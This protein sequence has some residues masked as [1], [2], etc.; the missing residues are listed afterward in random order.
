MTT[1]YFKRNLLLNLYREEKISLVCFLLPLKRDKNVW[2]LQAIS[3]V[4][5]PL[6]FLLVTLSVSNL[7][8]QCFLDNGWCTYIRVDAPRWQYFCPWDI[9]SKNTEVGSHSLLQGIFLSKKSNPALP[10]SDRFLTVWAVRKAH[11]LIL[12]LN[13]ASPFFPPSSGVFTAPLS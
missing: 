13:S 9:P 7:I 11:L 10:P 5:R 2:H 8:F 1:Q 4:W 3:S 12:I 6:A